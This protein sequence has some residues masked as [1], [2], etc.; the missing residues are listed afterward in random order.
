VDS[1]R[2]VEYEAA[3]DRAAV[4]QMGL[5]QDKNPVSPWEWR[6]EHRWV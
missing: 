2:R 5:W 3:E 1:I 4:D 6:R